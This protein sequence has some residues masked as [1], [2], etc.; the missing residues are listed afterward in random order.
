M[1]AVP[2]FY[3]DHDPISYPISFVPEQDREGFD[4]EKDF[5]DREKERKSARSKKAKS[6]LLFDGIERKEKR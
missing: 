1:V 3:F 2:A 4:Y 6:P 5:K